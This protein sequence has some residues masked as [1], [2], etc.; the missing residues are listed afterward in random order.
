MH[1]VLQDKEVQALVIILKEQNQSLY[2]T[3]IAQYEAKQKNDRLFT[4]EVI[5]KRESSAKFKILHALNILR[6]ENREISV[7][8]IAH[9][10]GCSNTIVKKYYTSI[11]SYVNAEH[12]T[13]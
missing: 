2:D 12:K 10:S 3:V 5:N 11:K 4:Q 13:V 6:M 8:T 9:E 7:D 1:I